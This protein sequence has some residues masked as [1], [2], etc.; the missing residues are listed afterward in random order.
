MTK[1]TTLGETDAIMV[2]AMYEAVIIRPDSKGNANLGKKCTMK[3]AL[4]IHYGIL[5]WANTLE[6]YDYYS[7][8]LGGW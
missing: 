5:E 8:D 1:G 4:S 3:E 6:Q 2:Y 7:D